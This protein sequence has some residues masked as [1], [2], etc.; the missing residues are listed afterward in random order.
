MRA[1]GNA[2]S[3]SLRGSDGKKY[4]ILLGHDETRETGYGP[5]KIAQ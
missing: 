4:E 2:K 3:C 1:L 5:G